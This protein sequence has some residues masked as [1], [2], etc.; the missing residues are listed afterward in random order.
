MPESLRWLLG[1]KQVPDW[2][3]GDSSW[4]IQFQ[5]LPQ[6]LSA[7]G[8]VGLALAA[9]VGV[10]Y[11]YR[12]ELSTVR[13][14]MRLLLMALRCG[15]LTCVAF[16]LLE[17]VLVI[18][19]HESI[20]SHLLVLVDSSES[21][22]L[23][24]PYPQD[25]TLGKLAA[26]LKFESALAMRKQARLEIA[27][28]A[29]AEVLGPLAENRELSMYSFGQQQLPL[30]K[31]ELAAIE[32]KGPAT[33]IGDALESALAEHRGQPLAGIL[34]VSDGQSNAG[35]DPRKVA[36]QAAKQGVPIVSFAIGTDEGPSN[37]RLAAI[38]ADPVVFVRDPT[39]IAVL[40]EAHGMQGAPAWSRWKSARTPAGAKLD[41]RKSRSTKTLPPAA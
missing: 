7:I 15:V 23:N 26:E 40:I 10:W 30:S 34:V 17:L 12:T 13:L 21:M 8:Y 27:R 20:P 29:L 5:S 22:G 37:A 32:P 11:L 24:D 31:D 28:R 14:G 16:M 41:A 35:E 33:A 6:G 39:E 38:E 3:S 36:E 2:V 18:T 1:L 4:A 25:E 19:K 9:V